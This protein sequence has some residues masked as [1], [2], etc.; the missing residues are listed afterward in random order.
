MWTGSDRWGWGSAAWPAA[1]GRLLG[2]TREDGSS[3]TWPVKAALGFVCVLRWAWDKRCLNFQ[4]QSVP[5]QGQLIY[6]LLLLINHPLRAF[7]CLHLMLQQNRSVSS[8]RSHLSSEDQAL[9]VGQSISRR[10][11]H[12][13]GLSCGGMFAVTVCNE[14]PAASANA[15]EAFSERSPPCPRPPGLAE[16][17]GRR[18]CAGRVTAVLGLCGFARL[19]LPARRAPR[20]AV[21]HLGR[22][23]LSAALLCAEPGPG[24]TPLRWGMLWDA[25]ELRGA[26]REKPNSS[27]CETRAESPRSWAEACWGPCSWGVTGCSPWGPPVPRGHGDHPPAAPGPSAVPWTWISPVATGTPCSCSLLGC[28]DSTKAWF[29][30]PPLSLSLWSPVTDLKL[31]ARDNTIKVC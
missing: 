28:W 24:L 12:P 13:G 11:S 10:S 27:R 18:R 31:S 26:S 7:R 23:T 5:C 9:V 8:P 4:Q 21:T 29:H 2:E 15:C 14:A 25:P 20:S 19:C 1:P 17:G 30:F 22:D 6:H 3:W 16:L